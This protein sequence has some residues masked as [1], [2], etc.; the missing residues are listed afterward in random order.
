MLRSFAS[1]LAVLQAP[2]P[3]L[4]G[5]PGSRSLVWLP[6]ALGIH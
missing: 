1:G 2:L 5:S 6:I 3:H 4:P